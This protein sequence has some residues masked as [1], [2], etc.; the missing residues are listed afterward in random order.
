MH[1][2]EAT[3]TA[4]DWAAVLAAAAAFLDYAP[5]IAAVLAGIYTLMRI[6]ERSIIWYR[7]LKEWRRGKG[8]A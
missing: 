8:E 6:V 5:G 7:K 4:L 3:K 1:V 2:D